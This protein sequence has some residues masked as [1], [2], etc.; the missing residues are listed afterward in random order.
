MGLIGGFMTALFAGPH[1]IA[2]S[3]LDFIQRPL[4]WAEMVERYQVHFTCAPNFA[5][6]LLLRKLGEK[7][8]TASWS[9]VRC[10]IFGGEPTDASVVERLRIELGMPS[11]AVWNMYG[12]AE[13]G[14]CVT[15][16]HAISLDGLVSCGPADVPYATIR[17]VVEGR[18]VADGELGSIWVRSA[19]VAS[20]YWGQPE[21]TDDTFQNTLEGEIGQWL[22]TGDLGKLVDGQLYVTGRLK[23][24]IIIQGKNYYPTDLERTIDDALPNEVRPGSTAAFQHGDG[25]GIVAEAR[26]GNEAV[27]DDELLGRVRSAVQREHGAEVVYVRVLRERSVPKTTS[28][29]LR[30]NAIR[31]CSSE[32]NWTDAQTL[33]RWVIHRQQQG[34]AAA[35]TQIAAMARTR[36][37]SREFTA[38]DGGGGGAAQLPLE[39]LAEGA[40]ASEATE[41]AD[42]S[43]QDEVEEL[44]GDLN[45][46]PFCLQK[47]DAIVVGAGIIG[48]CFA[49]DL[50][51]LGYRTLIIEKESQVGGVWA[52]NDYPGL[53][54]HGPGCSYRCLSLA[55]HWTKEH[56]PKEFYRPTRAEIMIYCQELSKHPNIA[57]LLG[58]ECNHERHVVDND[59][60]TLPVGTVS[61]QARFLFVSTGISVSACGTPVAPIEL[62][63]NVAAC[64]LGPLCLHSSQLTPEL[65]E[66]VQASTGRVVV[67]GSGKAAL[68]IL[69]QLDPDKS[70]LWAH[71]GH[72]AFWDRSKIE[73]QF[74][75]DGNEMKIAVVGFMSRASRGDMHWSDLA[76]QEGWLISCKGPM[77]AR[78]EKNSTGTCAASELR[79]ADRFQ[80]THLLKVE[81]FDDVSLTCVPSPHTDEEG[82]ICL[83]KED[84]IVF[85]TGQRN[86]RWSAPALS[87]VVAHAPIISNT[88]P[89]NALL[90]LC[91]ALGQLEAGPKFQRL[92]TELMELDAF[93]Q[94]R[95][96]FE[97][98]PAIDAREL[99][100][101]SFRCS[102]VWGMALLDKSKADVSFM[103]EWVG[104]WH[105]GDLDVRDVMARLCSVLPFRQASHLHVQ[106]STTHITAHAVVVGAGIVGLCF[107]RDLASLGYDVVLLER[108]SSVGGTWSTNDYPGLRLHQPGCS[109]RC[110]SLAPAWTKQHLPGEN[111]RPMRDEILQYCQ[112]LAEYANA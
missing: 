107:A 99:D 51:S 26:K 65:F 7:G 76:L 34:A 38:A 24:V 4:L 62:P 13:C 74:E 1:T 96:R 55:P 106:L 94:L 36:R 19:L 43:G 9:H 86:W 101:E 31:E 63:L 81:A 60:V 42:F 6:A 10:A 39:S 52:T 90:P 17:I 56:L 66:R 105:G 11:S 103:R 18:R 88:G 95:T 98:G 61:Y 28:G 33:A 85:C 53:R 83:R 29:K 110:L 12:M 68:D 82:R 70:V 30:R 3:P 23:D 5:F 102:S 92:V 100:R 40:S 91:L 44:I 97:L 72:T 50:A 64:P 84:C 108:S 8:Q 93:G 87:H 79:H 75:S 16:A 15:A 35:A 77:T 47:T 41:I 67:V 57:L 109:Y 46:V 21:L 48:L 111:Y 104:E 54:L 37:P 80:Q 71:R 112:E 14:L 2:C 59:R 22:D 73:S 69:Q 20:G 49:R 27:A 25:V 89:L 58:T 32:G 78:R 45:G